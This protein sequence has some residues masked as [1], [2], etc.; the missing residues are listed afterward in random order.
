[1]LIKTLLIPSLFLLGLAALCAVCTALIIGNPDYASTGHFPNLATNALNAQT[2]A[3]LMQ[4]SGT[5]G[6]VVSR[7]NVTRLEMEDALAQFAGGSKKGD[8]AVV[9]RSILSTI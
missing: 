6:K 7:K 8:E 4:A 5:F 3:A 1:M 2:M 9:T